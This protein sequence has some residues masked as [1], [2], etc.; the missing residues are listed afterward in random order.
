MNAEIEK[1]INHLQNTP[2]E[3]LTEIKPDLKDELTAHTE[4]G[5]QPNY[6]NFQTSQPSSHINEKT[7]L[8]EA[9]NGTNLNVGSLIDATVAVNLFDIVLPTIFAAVLKAA[10]GRTVAVSRF[11]ARASEKETI[12]PVLDGYLKSINF[13]VENP[14]NALLLVIAVIYAPKVIEVMNEPAPVVKEAEKVKEHRPLKTS[15]FADGET[16]KRKGQ[17]TSSNQ[18]AR[19]GRP[20]GSVKRK[21]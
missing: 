4:A 6:D 13:N 1:Q 14:F 9:G 20:A 5:F 10:K 2:P 17:F 12:K 16:V 15:T 21:L 7:G 11:Q 3:L 19:K 8:N 18:P